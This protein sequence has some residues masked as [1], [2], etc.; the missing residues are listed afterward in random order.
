[1]VEYPRVLTRDELHFDIEFALKQ[2]SRGLL[3]EWA[4]TNDLKSEQ[5]RSLM[6]STILS[7]FDRYQVR[8]QG[9]SDVPFWSVGNK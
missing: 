3:R 2:I 4:S 8:A 9:P 7:R 6:V 1:M 5:A